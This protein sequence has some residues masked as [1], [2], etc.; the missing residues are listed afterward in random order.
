MVLTPDDE[1]EQEA[2]RRVAEMWTKTGARLCRM[3][4]GDHD[5]LMAA[6]SHLPHMAA[7][8]IVNAVTGQGS[9]R[10][11]LRFAAGGFRDF[12]RIASSSPTMWRDIALTNRDALLASMDALSEQLAEIRAAV[13]EG[14]GAR[15]AELFACAKQA[16]DDWLQSNGEVS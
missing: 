2:E 12:T 15:L 9:D 11:A 13:A 16:R 1:T 3:P 6:V 10:D 7:F 8:A 5:R 14:D 4:V